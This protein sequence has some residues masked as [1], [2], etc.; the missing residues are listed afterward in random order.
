MKPPHGE[1]AI[2][3]KLIVDAEEFAR[4]A[5]PDHDGAVNVRL[6]MEQAFRLAGGG[7]RYCCRNYKFKISFMSLRFFLNVSAG[8]EMR[9]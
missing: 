7:G 9:T 6:G 8:M 1:I 3:G 2:T 5:P 4:Y